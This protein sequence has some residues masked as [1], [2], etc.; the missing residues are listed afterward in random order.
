ME[1]LPQ[2]QSQSQPQS[3][4][5]PSNL[6]GIFPS[7]KVSEDDSGV[8][9]EV[10]DGDGNDDG[11][12]DGVSNGMVR[13]EKDITSQ[14][15]GPPEEDIEDSGNKE[16]KEDLLS[17]VIKNASTYSPAA[18]V[19]DVP[20]GSDANLCR[21]LVPM[22]TEDEFLRDSDLLRDDDKPGVDPPL[23]PPNQMACAAPADLPNISVSLAVPVLE[24]P[25]KRFRVEKPEFSLRGATAVAAG[26]NPLA[27]RLTSAVGRAAGFCPVDLIAKNG[28]DGF[29]QHDFASGDMPPL[30][31]IP[32]P[33]PQ[34]MGE[35]RFLAVRETAR[36]NIL[37]TIRSEP[38]LTFLLFIRDGDDLYIPSTT[39]FDLIV[40]KMEIHVMTSR[41]DLLSFSWSGDKWKNCG[42][43]ELAQE[44]EL[45]EWRLA[46]SKLDLGVSFSADT[47]PHDSL[48]FGPDVSALL[49]DSYWSYDLAW[50]ARSLTYRNRTLKGY[51]RTVL[52]KVYEAHDYTRHDIS[53]NNWRLVYLSGDCVFME[54][55]SK[56]PSS[57]R[58]KAGPACTVLRGGIRKPAFLVEPSRTQFSWVRCP[59]LPTEPVRALAPL[60]LGRLTLDSSSSSSSV[61]SPPAQCALPALDTPASSSSSSSVV[62]LTK[63]A[64]L[65]ASLS[66]KKKTSKSK[67]NPKPKPKYKSERL[68]AAQTKRKCC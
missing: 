9:I 49:K 40:S 13:V 63:A 1:F 32:D 28:E 26:D 54:F 65:P 38:Q 39:L 34:V 4:A 57:H 55:L 37:R 15:F 30:P 23:F 43:L 67:S 20:T 52:S 16:V 29:L 41:P 44:P 50:F 60:T 46:L 22:N 5:S 45:E 12:G 47:F 18:E 21:V 64:S 61:A 58:F 35:E 66:S 6:S 51:V 2:P 56:F 36:S 42:I 68:K 31:T 14:E 33:S 8:G 48:L 53:M 10:V 11:D 62:P 25:H 59:V 3:M 7:C 17:E 24:R 19:L 27:I